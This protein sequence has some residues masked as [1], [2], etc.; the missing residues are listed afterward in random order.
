MDVRNRT[1]LTGNALAR[2]SR[3][4]SMAERAAVKHIAA[5]APAMTAVA[6][7][8]T[9]ISPPFTLNSSD[10]PVMRPGPSARSSRDARLPCS[11]SRLL[12]RAS[13]SVADMLIEPA[14]HHGGFR[15]AYLEVQIFRYSA[16]PDLLGATIELEQCSIVDMGA[17]ERPRGGCRR[18]QQSRFSLGG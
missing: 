9:I 4:I 16:A 7:Q 5:A 14:A 17:K 18:G 3:H 2:D 6:I 15:C 1:P 10:A 12:R 11:R 13:V 8:P